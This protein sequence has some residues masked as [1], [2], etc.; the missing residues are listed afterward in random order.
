MDASG[1][2]TPTL[3]ALDGMGFPKPEETEIGVDFAYSTT[4]FEL[5]RDARP[6]WKTAI[7]HPSAPGASRGAVM[8][9]IESDQWIVGVGGNHGDVPPGDLEGFLAFVKTLRTTTAYEAIR[10][11]KP[12]GEIFRYQLPC[13][14]RRHFEKLSRFP[15]GLLVV[16]DA[17]CRFNPVYAQGMSVAAQEAVILD[18]LLDERAGEIDPLDALA[19]AFFAAV[20]AVLE[21]P[22]GIANNDFIYPKTR[23]ARPADFEQ[24]LKFN[25][26][27]AHLGAQDPSVHRLM[28]EVNQLLKPQSALRTPEIIERVTGLMALPHKVSCHC[29]VF[30]DAEWLRTADV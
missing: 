25:F 18:R 19:P 15:R 10:D 22:W 7:V 17:L 4:I 6:A 5:P 27:L 1:R 3:A 21:T 16:G 8:A 23:G 12:V 28:F 9:Q 29:S 26:A 13:S 24:R 30:S 20:Q 14:T 11:A 2:G